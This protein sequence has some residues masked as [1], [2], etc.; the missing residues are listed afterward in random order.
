MEKYNIYAGLGGSFGGAQYQYTIEAENRE[1]AENIAYN[2]AVEIYQNF[3][4][5]YGIMDWNNCAISLE[6]DPCTED[7]SL[8]A[9]VDDY[10]NNE[11][12]EWINYYVILTSDDKEISK[13]DLIYET[14]E[15]NETD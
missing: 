7:D 11:V 9:E 15:E 10:Y 4:G 12:E 3:E 2:E 13:E 6:I 14:V 5:T 8:I 1:E